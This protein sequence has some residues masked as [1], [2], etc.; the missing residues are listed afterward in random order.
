MTDNSSIK[1]S[2]ISFVS[3]RYFMPV[4]KCCTSVKYLQ[5]LGRISRYFAYG[6]HLVI[7]KLASFACVCVCVC[8]EQGAERKNILFG[9]SPVGQVRQGLELD[10]VD[11]PIGLDTIDTGTQLQ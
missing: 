3:Q 7:D 11:Y 10:N 6:N 9:V 2:K 5:P 8:C 1:M 4:E